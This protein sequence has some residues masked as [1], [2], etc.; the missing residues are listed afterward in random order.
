M[1]SKTEQLEN[2]EQAMDGLQKIT[3][4]LENES[5]PLKQ[6]IERFEQGLDLIEFCEKR[7]EEAELLIEEIDDTDPD[8]PVLRR[9]KEED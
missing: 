4:E 7:L 2:F 1:N 9:K 8:K 6:A 5:I 3:A